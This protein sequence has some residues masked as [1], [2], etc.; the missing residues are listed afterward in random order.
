MKTQY[1][2]GLIF[3]AVVFGAAVIISPTA[4]LAVCD[5]E[6]DGPDCPCFDDTGA[7]N[8][9]GVFIQD[10]ASLTVGTRESCV[11]DGGKPYYQMVL[12]C[13]SETEAMLASWLIANFYFSGSFDERE[14]WCSETIA[15]WHRE[16]GT[17][18]KGGYSTGWH[19]DW[20][21]HGVGTLKEWY[22]TE[23]DGGRGRWIE[24]DDVDYDNFELGVTVPVPGA[25]V[26]LREYDPV[27]QEWVAD[28][29]AHSV[30][31]N[32]MWL[33]Q[34]VLGN[35]F[36]VEVSL[37]EGN[38]SEKVKETGHWDDILSLTPQ[39]SEWIGSKKIYG[40]GIDLNYQ[41]DPIYDASRLHWV[42]HPVIYKPPQTWMVYPRDP[43]WQWYG[44]RI[45]RLKAYARTLR[46][47]GEPNVVCSD[48][49]LGIVDIPDG[50][51]TRWHFPK[52]LPPGVEIVIDLLDVHPLPIK[53]IE[54]RWAGGSLPWN[55]RVQYASADQRYTEAILPKPPTG[56]PP[57]V[58]VPIPVPVRFSTS[59]AGVQVRYVKL[60]FHGTFEEDA[61]LESLRF[62]YEQG[63]VGDTEGSCLFRLAGDVDKDC[64]VDFR[65]LA[66]MGGNWLAD[67]KTS[68]PDP[69]CVPE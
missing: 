53:G 17:P 49:E 60:I 65:D 12:G 66:V 57:T 15:Y 34:D 36:E 69:A 3:W 21:I 18:Y 5:D 9:G 33:H 68:P 29:A 56:L 62:R 8:P 61:I 46:A 25:Y 48:P 30:M 7:W 58:T 16:D 52:G 14:W 59:G 63:P 64:R 50:N 13:N 32:E 47:A 41:G 37:L 26:A 38:S 43:V 55:Y 42:S 2:P 51:S 20:Q 24:P 4:G 45:A 11:E 19:L 54:L 10:V 22:T 23:E 39:G 27:A 31:I 67:C 35:V 28:G 40:F 44:N 1:N 6:P